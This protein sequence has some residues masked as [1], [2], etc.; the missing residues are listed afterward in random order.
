[1]KLSHFF[2]TKN[3]HLAIVG[4][5]VAA[6]LAPLVLP[7][8]TAGKATPESKIDWQSNLDQA[9]ETA[10]SEDKPVLLRFTASWCPPCLVMNAKVWPD[11]NVAN[12]VTSGYVPVEIDVDSP[13]AAEIT[14]KFRIQGVP[15]V[16]LLDPK[17]QETSRANFMSTKQTL[18]FLEQPAS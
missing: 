11:A 5:A 14:E 18:R 17:G 1:M 15:S 8:A 2:T 6:L 9:L 13:A 10:A 3:G 7:L 12:A 16:V 4:I